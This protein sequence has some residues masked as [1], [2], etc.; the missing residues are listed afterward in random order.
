M[1]IAIAGLAPM[2]GLGR[3]WVALGLRL[4]GLG[5][6]QTTLDLMST[7]VSPFKRP[8]DINIFVRI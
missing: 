5:F 8:G 4:L 3:T 2:A 7:T 1:P 6:T